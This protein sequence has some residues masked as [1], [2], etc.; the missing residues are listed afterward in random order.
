[1]AVSRCAASPL[2]ALFTSPSYAHLWHA[3]IRVHLDAH[4]IVRLLAACRRMHVDADVLTGLDVTPRD[5]LCAFNAA[6]DFAQAEAGSQRYGGFAR[7]CLSA[8]AAKPRVVA[9]AAIWALHKGDLHLGRIAARVRPQ[10][11]AST[12]RCH[13]MHHVIANLPRPGLFP[14]QTDCA[15]VLFGTAMERL[16]LCDNIWHYMKAA[17]A[18]ASVEFCCWLALLWAN[19]GVDYG[20][21]S[22][23]RANPSHMLGS[24][25]RGAC[26]VSRFGVARELLLL[27]P[28]DRIG[29]HF[30]AIWSET[31][32]PTLHEAHR[33]GADKEAVWNVL[34]Q[35]AG[36]PHMTFELIGALRGLLSTEHAWNLWWAETHVLAPMDP[37][38]LQKV[39]AAMWGRLQLNFRMGWSSTG[40]RPINPIFYRHIASHYGVTVE[41]PRT[42]A[43][44][45]ALT[46]G[47]CARPLAHA[48]HAWPDHA[49]LFRAAARACA[50]ELQ[51]TQ[52]LRKIA[53]GGCGD[54]DAYVYDASAGEPPRSLLIAMPRD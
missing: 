19:A 11:Y 21:E 37:E 27:I 26:K 54:A 18:L 25:L 36:P 14:L 34:V 2:L 9:D 32:M 3:C 28:P 12:G 40:A 38:R 31:F 10:Y 48:A 16:D 13:G 45:W 43:N 39:N 44:L 1:M 30:E 20:G 49:A 7:A 52:L 42:L 51:F 15:K 8:M 6:V 29:S 47:A 46:V 53:A 41:Q 35:S 23:V 4:S 17:G 22:D 50:Q 24:A 5:A 33:F